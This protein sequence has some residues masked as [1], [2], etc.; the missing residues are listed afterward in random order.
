MQLERDRFGFCSFRPS[1][2]SST[3][4]Y[5]FFA[6]SRDGAVL[7]FERLDMGRKQAQEIEGIRN[8]PILASAVVEEVEI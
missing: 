7:A 4:P 6:S 8:R 3:Y 5:E 2:S 1:S